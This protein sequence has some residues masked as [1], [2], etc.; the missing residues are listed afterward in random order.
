MLSTDSTARFTSDVDDRVGLVGQHWDVISRTLISLQ[1]VVQEKILALLKTADI[2]SPSTNPQSQTAGSAATG[3]EPSMSSLPRR[4]MKLQPGAL[5]FDADL[6]KSAEL[7]GSRVV[8]GVKIPRV[9]TGQGRWGVWREEARCLG[10]WAGGRDQNF[11]FFNLLTAFLGCH[12]DWLKVL[13]PTWHRRRYREQQ[14]SSPGENL[15]V[16][17]RTVIISADKMAARRLIFLLST[18]LPTSR[19]SYD[20]VSLLRPNTSVSFQ[21][22]SQSPPSGA[23]ISRQ[24]SLRRTINRRGGSNA[25]HA[26]S[27]GIERSAV[28]SASNSIESESTMKTPNTGDRTRRSSEARSIVKANL[29]APD[30]DPNTRK[31][32]AATTSTTTPNGVVPVPH[33]SS[34]R[35]N[36]I[37]GSGPTPRPGS[38]GSLASANLMHTLQRN[39]SNNTSSDSQSGSR[40]GSLKSLWSMGARRDSSTDQSELMYG[41][42]EGLGI[43]SVNGSRTVDRTSRTKLEQMVSELSVDGEW[44]PED[45]VQSEPASANTTQPSPGLY[46][47]SNETPSLG[48]QVIPQLSKSTE[49]PPPLK[50]SVNESDGVI[51]VEIPYLSFGSPQS[52]PIGRSNSTSSSLGGSSFGQPSTCSFIDRDTDHPVNVAG[53]L[54]RFHPDFTLQAVNPYPDLE[55]DIRRTMSAEPTPVSAATTPNLD[56][57]PTEKWVDVCTT[58]IADTRTF[59]IKRLRLRR[60]VRL[61]PASSQPA[62]ASGRYAAPIRSQYGNPYDQSSTAPVLPMT[63]LHLKDAFAE[64]PIVDF[65]STLVDAIERVLAQSGGSSRAH[66][67]TSSRSSSRRGRKE[68]ASGEDAAAPVDVQKGECKQIVLGALEQIVKAVAAEMAAG[69][70]DEGESKGK[71]E[72]EDEDG[73]SA[74]REEHSGVESTLREGIRKW[75]GQVEELA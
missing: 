7:A 13:G 64:E 74:G 16:S 40:W 72:S 61:I 66:S 4:S 18:F 2:T 11:F 23:A 28:S 9:V 38:S 6:Q 10:R 49:S 73:A 21:A 71:D 70:G 57:G 58:L 26:R 59:S 29:A 1:F 8:R 44:Y 68:R 42:D 36:S 37:S 63:E 46:G 39:N 3:R 52:L 51:D 50:M 35:T 41:T 22:F 24:Q 45:L 25:S 12:V 60:L 56:Q 20:G 47:T 75:L 32:S 48:G 54:G 27:S 67:A 17:S 19:T 34:H 65:D 69:E 31:S 5:A 14:K 62:V 53:W 55:A 43:S 33:F 30:T 15:T